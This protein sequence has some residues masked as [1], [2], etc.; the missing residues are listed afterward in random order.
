M[1]RLLLILTGA[2]IGFILAATAQELTQRTDQPPSLSGTISNFTVAEAPGPAPLTEFTGLDGATH[3][4]ADFQGKVL[5]IN[6]WATWCGPCKREMPAL[7]RLQAE[8]GGDEF[9]VMLISLDRLGAAHVAPFLDEMGLAGL[10]SYLDPKM[11]LWRDLGGRGLPT[12][13]LLAP[14]GTEIGR[15]E[16]PAEWDAREAM[17]LVRYHIEGPLAARSHR[18]Q[19]RGDSGSP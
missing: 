2:A 7:D 13:I 14:D 16:G 1:K 9:A 17:A 3:T 8:L 10:S 5:A 19:L 15:L 18:G 4:L 11:R 6:F 12:T